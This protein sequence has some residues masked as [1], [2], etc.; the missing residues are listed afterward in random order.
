MGKRDYGDLRHMKFFLDTEFIE[1]GPDYPIY[2]LSIGIVS[3]DDREYYAVIEQTPEHIARADPWVQENVIRHIDFSVAKCRKVVAQEIVAFCGQFPKFWGYYCSYD[4]V[5][6]CQLYGTMMNLPNGWPKF[7]LD[8]KQAAV[9][10]G[11]PR[12]P[13]MPGTT[14]HNALWDAKEIK[15][16]Y[17]W[18][19]NYDQRMA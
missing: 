12:L 4:F 3:E 14:K 16:R 10:M 19:M 8:L 1:S 11:N 15:Y 17:D 18:L 7:C 9:F 2:P 5:L 13:N 6:L